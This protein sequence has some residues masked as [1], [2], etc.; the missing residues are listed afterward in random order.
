MC[1]LSP[2][3]C[4]PKIKSHQNPFRIGEIADNFLDWRGQAPD[5]RWHGNDLV[6]TGQRRTFQQINNLDLINAMKVL[7]AK[8]FK[9]F[10]GAD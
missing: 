9:V 10:K 1:S 3:T 8:L 2:S 4:G 7:F 5:E 6:A